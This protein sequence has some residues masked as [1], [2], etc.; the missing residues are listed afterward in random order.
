[1]RWSS[2]DLICFL[3]GLIN[4]A[5]LLK[6]KM[7][8]YRRHLL[9]RL[10]DF[11]FTSAESLSADHHNPGPAPL[12][13]QHVSAL[14]VPRYRRSLRWMAPSVSWLETITGTVNFLVFLIVTAVFE[15]L[16]LLHERLSLPFVFFRHK[17][18]LL[19]FSET[20]LVIFVHGL[21]SGSGFINSWKIADC[22]LWCYT[23]VMQLFDSEITKF[24]PKTFGLVITWC[25]LAE[26]IQTN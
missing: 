8:K 24:W 22:S 12:V 23:K 11:L 1:M 6:C 15:I 5:W 18:F 7:E 2:R 4:S 16:L 25:F 13:A 19:G 3:S 9:W 26:W 14:L 10:L 17:V 20:A 21:W